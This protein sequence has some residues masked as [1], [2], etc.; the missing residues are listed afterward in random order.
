MF[1]TGMLLKQ[2]SP[3]KKAQYVMGSLFALGGLLKI[4][5]R[6]YMETKQKYDPSFKIVS[7]LAEENQQ[8]EDSLQRARRDL[9]NNDI[10]FFESKDG[11]QKV[12]I[13]FVNSLVGE[14]RDIINSKNFD[15]F[16]RF[17]ADDFIDEIE[18]ERKRDE[19]LVNELER[20]HYTLLFLFDLLQ[21]SFQF[22]VIA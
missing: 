17:T 20:T 7:P 5:A 4:E 9:S 11:L 21:F 1:Y 12:F 6:N 10:L 13:H 8:V 16:M 15:Y 22:L 19:K 3:E 14:D 2:V 18:S